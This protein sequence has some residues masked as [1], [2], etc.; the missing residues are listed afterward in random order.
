MLEITIPGEE[1]FDNVNER[2]IYG[3]PCTLKLEHSLLS[4][5]KWEQQWCI[6]F[7]SSIGKR[8]E[9]TA[10]QIFDYIKCMTINTVD[11]SVYE[12][13]REPQIKEIMAYIESPHSALKYNNNT[14]GRRG[15][16]QGKLMTNE[17]IYHWMIVFGIPFSCEKWHL[18]HLLALISWCN[19]EEKPKKKMSKH[20]LWAQNS[21]LNAARKAGRK[22]H[23]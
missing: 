5:S 2:F 3:K 17:T 7:L 12:R 13:L 14:P 19:E 20:D 9:L 23:L 16:V 11:D 15:N 4:L 21:A 18:N 1:Y 8:G 22:P 6:P 10:E